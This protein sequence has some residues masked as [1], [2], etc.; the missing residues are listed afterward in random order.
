MSGD[1]SR[2]E[3]IFQEYQ[4]QHAVFTDLHRQIQAISVTAASPRREVEVTVDHSGKVTG[5]DFTGSAYKRLA[6]KELSEL[7]MRTLEDAKEQAA[8]QSAELLTPVMPE[9]LNARDLVSG[10]LGID[11]L[12]PADGPRLPR[13]VREQLQR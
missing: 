13:I 2:V 4:R 8:D 10:R 12:A 3:Q 11:K 1:T 6:P 5:I 7:I 9:G